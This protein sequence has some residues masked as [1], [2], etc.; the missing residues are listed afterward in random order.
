MKILTYMKARKRLLLFAVIVLMCKCNIVSA[1]EPMVGSQNGITWNKLVLG[2]GAETLS[3]KTFY[4]DGMDNMSAF[5]SQHADLQTGAVDYSE[6]FVGM[7]VGQIREGLDSFYV[8]QKNLQ[9]PII[10]AV[11]IVRL[12]NARVENLEVEDILRQ[13]REAT[14][15]GPDPSREKMIWKVALK[16]LK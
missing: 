12:Q 7:N 10:D 14:I 6:A 15:N 3:R 5:W 13:F 9:I 2:S 4:V 16:I 1:Q 11:L 8:D